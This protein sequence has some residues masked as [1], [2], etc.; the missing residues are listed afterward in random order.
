[1]TNHPGRA[2]GSAQQRM[3]PADLR[4]LLERAEL[5]QA[6][7]AALAGVKLRTMQQYLAGDRE[8]PQSASGSLCMALL[9]TLDGSLPVGQWLPTEVA[10]ALRL[11]QPC[12][13]YGHAPD[14]GF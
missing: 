3:T 11:P 8:M 9:L 4:A 12:H 14:P 7:A 2:P 6:R 5:T 10:A 13:V 1:M